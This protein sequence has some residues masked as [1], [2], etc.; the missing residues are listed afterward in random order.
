[1]KKLGFA[2][3]AAT[4]LMSSG[5]YAAATDSQNVTINANVPQEC[6]IAAPAT[7]NLTVNINQDPGPDALLINGDSTDDQTFWMSCNY[8]AN[9]KVDSTNHGLSNPNPVGG[10]SGDFT[11]KINYFFDLHPNDGGTHFNRV[12]MNTRYVFGNS[13]MAPGAFHE[14]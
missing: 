12:V 13:A 6:S 14:L 5:A 2:A 11:N 10:D 4:A 7:V 9:V 8:A 3:A 1:M